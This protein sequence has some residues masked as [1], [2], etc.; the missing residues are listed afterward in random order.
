M[1]LKRMFFFNDQEI[2]LNLKENRHDVFF[3][4]NQTEING[5]S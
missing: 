4:M 5:F 3:K 1:N 2:S